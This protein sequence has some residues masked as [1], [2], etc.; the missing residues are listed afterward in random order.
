MDLR[1]KILSDP[2]ANMLGIVPERIERGTYARCRV[3]VT[4]NLLNFYG[5]THDGLLL[6]LAE[7][8]FSAAAHTGYTPAVALNVSGIYFKKTK[9]GDTLIAEARLVNSEKRFSTYSIEIRN[10]DALV[11]SFSGTAARAAL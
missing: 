7:V 11:S 8:A 9:L 5:I 6:S 4:E 3:K 10:G 1:N 2:Y